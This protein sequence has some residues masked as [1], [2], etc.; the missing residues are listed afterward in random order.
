MASQAALQDLVDRIVQRFAP[1]RVILFGSHA[2]GDDNP[3]SDVDLFIEMSV[4]GIVGRRATA[5]RK[6]VGSCGFPLD[7]V[8]FTSEEVRYWSEAEASLAATVLREGRVLYE[9]A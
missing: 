8:V 4:D 2:R 6:A 1:E 5:V 7:I 3:N 9:R